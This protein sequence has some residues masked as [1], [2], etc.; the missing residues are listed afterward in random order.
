MN[1]NIF[2]S[3]VAALALLVAFNSCKKEDEFEFPHEDIKLLVED[4][5]VFTNYDEIVNTRFTNVEP[6]VSCVFVTTTPEYNATSGSW[7]VDNTSVEGGFKP[8]TKYYWYLSAVDK[9]GEYG[10][11]EIRSFYYVPAP[12]IDIHNVKGDWAA[13]VKWEKNDFLLSVQTITLK[14]DKDCKYDSNPISVPA[15]QD[16]CYISA[17]T[18]DNQKYQIYHNWWDE[19]HGKYYEPVIY[20]FELVMRYIIEGDTVSVAAKQK[21][22]FLNTDGYVADRDLNVYRYEKI[23]NRIWMLDDLRMKLDNNNLYYTV[24]LE[25]GLEMILYADYQDLYYYNY[26]ENL[27]PQG[28][29]L[30]THEDWLDLEAHFSVENV[31]SLWEQYAKLNVGVYQYIA[32]ADGVNKYSYDI[33]PDALS[34]YDHYNGK[35][36]HIRDYLIAD[37]EWIDF[38]DSSKKLKGNHI[39]YAHPAG[40]P[41][42]SDFDNMTIENPYVGY[43]VAF[44]TSSEHYCGNIKRI[45]WSGSDGI[46]KIQTRHEYD[47]NK[48]DVLYS[49]WR[50]VKDE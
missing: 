32:D 24:R 42:I 3:A 2:K 36:S 19:A 6:E 11:S 34:I 33:W 28:F 16:S 13:V 40:I 26:I 15:G 20:D 38:N 39:F 27:I 43:G 21:G 46:C 4:G 9:N 14:P 35:G 47:K 50:C 17:G 48:L 23:G 29:H 37:N 12:K 41:Y 10:Y 22:I 30:A 25:S 31:D 5:K 7:R 1:T 18:L 45:L 44:C 49:L 8:Y